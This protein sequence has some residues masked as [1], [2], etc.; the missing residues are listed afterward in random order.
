MKA[1]W[2]SNKSEICFGSCDSTQKIS[3][4]KINARLAK[5]QLH[6]GSSAT[7]GAGPLLLVF[8]KKLE[9]K[10]NRE[11]QKGWEID[12]SFFQQNFIRRQMKKS[13]PERMKIRFG[14]ISYHLN[15]KPY[16]IFSPKSKVRVSR[17]PLI[18]T[19]NVKWGFFEDTT[20]ETPHKQ[21]TVDY[22]VVVFATSCIGKTLW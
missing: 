19:L 2:N 3:Y 18:K 10:G 12:T 7:R 8:R 11:T 15:Q 1:F 6:R 17:K 20:Q 4:F 5:H 22:L 21:N 14:I 13:L 9:N 16:D